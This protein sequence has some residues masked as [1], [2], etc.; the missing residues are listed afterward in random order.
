MLTMMTSFGNEMLVVI[1]KFVTRTV[2]IRTLGKAYLGINGLFAD[3]ISMLSLAELGVDTAITY[4]LYK[5]LAEH[6]DKRVRVLLK[7]Y[8]QAYRVIGTVILL[9]GLAM[10]PLL[11]ILIRDYETLA[12]LNINAV[13]VFMMF[14]LQSVS[15]YWFFAYRS[16]IMIANQRKYVLDIAGYIIAVISNV[17]QILVLV[18][19]KN[20]IAYTATVLSFSVIANL[21]YALIAQRYFPQF[22][23]KEE[24]RLKK[25]EV[26]SLFKDC[27]A[28]FLYNVNGV[29]LKATDNIVLSSFLGLPMVG[30]YSNYLLFY[31]TITKLLGQVYRSVRASMGN[32]FVEADISRKFQMFKVM[33]FLT[34][35]LYGTAGVGITVCADELIRVWVSDSYVIAEPFALLIGIEIYLWG[36]VNNIYQIRNVSGTFRN[37]WYRPLFG[38]VINIVVSVGLVQVCGIYGVIIGTLSTLLLTNIAMDVHVVYKYSFEGYKPEIDYYLRNGLYLLVTAGVCLADR[39][40]C[41]HVYTGHGWLSVIVHILIVSVS[42]PAV[43]LLLFCKTESCRYLIGLFR[44]LLGKVKSKLRGKTKKTDGKS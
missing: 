2:F 10:I 19:L 34:V 5:P 42:V 37:M 3:V 36:L 9:M 44:N 30:L 33:N 31:T 29:V 23:T 15:S 43:F 16:T 17:A 32:L 41:S 25:E 40:I 38:V 26:L 28:V 18:F 11:P 7:F 24:D 20:F 21:V 6:D 35:V 14:L 12:D 13:L 22:F 39:W 8:K 4:Q 1:L 27:G